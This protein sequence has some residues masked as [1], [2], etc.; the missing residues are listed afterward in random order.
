MTKKWYAAGCCLAALVLAQPSL[1]QNTNKFTWHFGGGFTEPVDNASNRFERGYNILAGAGVNFTPRFGL[2]GEFNYND[3]DLTRSALTA[4]GVPDG[5]GRIYSFTANPIFRF[6][7]RGR[8][9]AYV[10]GGGGYYRR[11]VEF[12]QPTTTVVTAFDPFYGVFFPAE[13]PVN[14]VLGSF[15]QNKGGLNAGAGVTFSIHQDSNTKIFAEAR[16]HHIWT[17]PIQT[18]Y[19]PVTFGLRW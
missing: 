4:A 9:D 10:I 13:I 18:S 17:T 2:L 5:S 15:S 16:Y 7:P 14:Q 12:T 1:A 3:M 11:T 19:L 8:L 6:N